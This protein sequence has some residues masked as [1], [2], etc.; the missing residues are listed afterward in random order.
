MTWLR[1]LILFL[2][3]SS[4]QA[5]TLNLRVVDATGAPFPK[6]LVIVKSLDGGS[7]ISRELTDKNG[8][9]PVVHVGEGLYR[10]IATC[11]YSICETTV[12]EFLG[13]R[14]GPE[15]ALTVSMLATDHLGD[16]V[17]G[18][19]LRVVMTLPD[20]HLASG[21]HLLVRDLKATREKW[22]VADEKGSA[23]IELQSDPV[24]LLAV[25]GGS[26]FALQ[27]NAGCTRSSSGPKCTI[28]TSKGVT[29]QL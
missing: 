29:W 16:V 4:A 21:V 12:K 14:L 11:P 25:Y 13:A 27:V 28:D 19:T 24:V 18:P 17:G 20:G 1:L 15:M 23:I 8:R 7:E 22:Y 5:A 2:L 26:L 10:V 9:I 3:M 6:V